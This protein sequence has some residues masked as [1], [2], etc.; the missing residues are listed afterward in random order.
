MPNTPVATNVN[1]TLDVKVNLFS[2]L[3]LNLMLV[4]NKLPET[5]N[6][7]FSKAIRLS[8]RIN[9]SLS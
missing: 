1:E 5:I 8:I 7:F 6:L 9:T 3:T 2:K 4:V